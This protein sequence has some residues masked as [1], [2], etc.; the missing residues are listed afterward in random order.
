MFNS[1]FI[2]NHFLVKTSFRC[3]KESNLNS[4]INSS[5]EEEYYG[6]EEE[7]SQHSSSESR[8][9][10]KEAFLLADHVKANLYF[11]RVIPEHPYVMLLF[12]QNTHM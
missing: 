10:G 6:Y 12:V 11:S 3:Q 2:M 5:I 1:N 8:N 4:P 9:S 7:S